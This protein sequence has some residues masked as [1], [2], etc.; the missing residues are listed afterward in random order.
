MPRFRRRGSFRR[1]RR[2]FRRFRRSFRRYGRRTEIKHHDTE[3][4]ELLDDAGTIICLN[5]IAAGTDQG[6]RIGRNINTS[7][8]LLRFNINF[9]FWGELLGAR[10]FQF[11]H[12]LR[13]ILFWY[14]QPI[15]GSPITA[16]NALALILESTIATYTSPLNTTDQRSFRIIR[17]KVYNFAPKTTYINAGGFSVPYPMGI[18]KKWFIK[19]GLKRNVSYEDGGGTASSL[20]NNALYLLLVSNTVAAQVDNGKMDFGL[21]ARLRYYDM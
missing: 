14:V 20:Q 7:S 5:D 19:R 1:R 4:N 3:A 11:N 17:D 8:L 21:Y 18:T 9:N 12:R 13:V 16:T 10:Q 6:T 15:A 2:R